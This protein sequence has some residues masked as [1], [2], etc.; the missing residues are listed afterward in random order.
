MLVLADAYGFRV[1]L[2]QLGQRVHQS[3]SDGYGAPNGDVVFGK[4]I[5]GDFRGRIDGRSLLADAKHLD[6]A[7]ESLPFQE[8][9]GF[10]SCRPVADGYGVYTVGLYHLLDSPGGFLRLADGRMRID[11]FV[12]QQ[13]ALFV[14]AHHL[15][16]GA[17]T[18]VDAHHPFPAQ[19]GSQQQLAE[20]PGKDADGFVIGFF[21]ALCG[22]FGFDGGLQQTLVGILHGLSHLLSTSVGVSHK[23]VLELIHA[24][25]IVRIDGHFQQAF[26][27]C[28]ADGQ[29]LVRAA[30]LQG[31]GEVKVVPVFGG[32]CFFSFYHLGR[33]NGLPGKGVA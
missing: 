1:N 21:L 28:T 24:F 6:V 5:A 20:I 17:E 8:I 32:F 4:L 3:A 27:F 14:Q 10:P 31:V 26:G 33:Q 18:R 13:V 22:K 2:H 23:T 15:A 19:W 11:V 9:L 25:F 12:V 16:S 7:P 30:S 29:Q